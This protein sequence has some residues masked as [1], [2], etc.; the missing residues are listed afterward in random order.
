MSV[1][2]HLVVVRWLGRGTEARYTVE[3]DRWLARAT[4]PAVS[5]EVENPAPAYLSPNFSNVA[6]L[7][8]RPP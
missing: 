3:A 6:G 4:A 2:S 8:T 5:D 1:E 7:T